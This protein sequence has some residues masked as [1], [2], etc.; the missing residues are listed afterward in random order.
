MAAAPADIRSIARRH[1]PLAI[2]T[3]A[4][5]CRSSESDSA[6]VGAATAL[7]DRGWGKSPQ[8]ITGENGEGGIEVI[9]RHIIEGRA[10]EPALLELKKV[11]D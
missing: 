5:I 10:R 2:E 9:V 6:R 7:L 11:E 3:L 4:Q 8:A 1:T